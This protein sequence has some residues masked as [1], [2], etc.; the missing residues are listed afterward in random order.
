MGRTL[1]RTRPATLKA[2]IPARIM[3]IT[4]A[5]SAV[6]AATTTS[7]AVSGAMYQARPASEPDQQVQYPQRQQVDGD[8]HGHDHPGV[9]VAEMAVTG[10]VV[11]GDDQPGAAR[12]DRGEHEQMPVPPSEAGAVGGQGLRDLVVEVDPPHR[13]QDQQTARDDAVE[14]GVEP[15]SS[16]TVW[17]AT[18]AGEHRLTQHDDRE[19][20]VALDDV[21]GGAMTSAD[22]LRPDG[23]EQLARARTITDAS[24]PPGSDEKSDPPHLA[25]DDPDC[26]TPCTCAGA[27]SAPADARSQWVTWARRMTT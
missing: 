14:L 22:P 20:S 23:N 13:E 25:D 18:V 1:S 4:S 6:D 21:A 2:I 5:G 3:P 16:T 17:M 24:E 7:A 15:P 19:Q 12:G 11:D 27:G 26:E 10:G 9:E 8:G